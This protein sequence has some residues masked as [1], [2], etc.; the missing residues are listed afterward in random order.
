MSIGT[1]AQP[2]AV[3]A[4]GERE[5]SPEVAA[6]IG[7]S[8]ETLLHAGKG[9]KNRLVWGTLS[10]VDGPGRVSL[11]GRISNPSHFTL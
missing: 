9:A 4:L 7:R 1:R 3:A 6:V 11:V 10:G 5:T 8:Q 2:L